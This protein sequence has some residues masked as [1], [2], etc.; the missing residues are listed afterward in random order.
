MS[1]HRT[2]LTGYLNAWAF[3][4]LIVLTIGSAADGAT[5]T[6]EP[7]GDGKPAVVTID[8]DLEPNDGDR[9][10]LKQAFCQKPLFLFEATGAVLSRAFKS[11]RAFE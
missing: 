3:V 6:V 5:I 1:N 10:R 11:A 4:A 9:F 8:G 7:T 2:R